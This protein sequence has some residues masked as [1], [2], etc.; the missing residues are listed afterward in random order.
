M[1][2]KNHKKEVRLCN[3]NCM[4]FLYN[5]ITRICVTKTFE[6]GTTEEKEHFYD[7]SF[8]K[9]SANFSNMKSKSIGISIFNFKE[10]N[11]YK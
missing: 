4:V 7:E 2:S 6:D 8:D 9:L 10:Y 3:V 11:Y 1:K 5:N